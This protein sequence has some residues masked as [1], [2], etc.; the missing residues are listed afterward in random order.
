[1]FE[2]EVSSV[3]EKGMSEDR[4]KGWEDGFEERGEEREGEVELESR[5]FGDQAELG[6][7]RGKKG[8]EVGVRKSKIEHVVSMHFVR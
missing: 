1:V 3:G 4:A 7:E 2:D 5:E 8:F 6:I